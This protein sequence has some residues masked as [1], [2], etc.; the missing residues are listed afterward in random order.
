[1]EDDYMPR[2]ADG[3][4]HERLNASGALLIEGPKWCG[5]TTTGGRLCSSALFMQD[6]DERE[7]NMYYAS[8]RP[9]RLLEG[10][11]PRLIDEWQVAPV[12]WDAVRFAV[13]RDGG[14]GLFVLTGSSVPNL[15][16][17]R[18]KMHSGTGR[19]SR[20]RMHT[21]SLFESGESEGS[22]SVSAL[23]NG[24]TDFDCR[25]DL[26]MERLAFA[27]CRG[28]WPAAVRMDERY[29]L[30][31]A[32]DYVESVST[33][34]ISRAD[35]VMRD[36]Y[37]AKAL[38][39]SLAR[40][41][42]TMAETTAIAEDL[43]GVAS[44]KTVTEYIAALRRI[45]VCDDIPAWRPELMSK[46]RLRTSPKRCFSDPSIAAAAIG[47]APEAL[48]R[49]GPAFGS[50][51]ESLCVRDMRAYL[52]P[53]DGTVMHYHDST[54]LEADMILSLPDGRWA[55]VEV[56]L[57]SGEDKA[58]ENLLRLARKTKTASGDGPSFLAVVTGTGMFRERD[59]G[60]LAI[61]IGCLGP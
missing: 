14:R 39:A 16:K 47:A 17:E 35:G 26:T 55:A 41:V 33:S 53:L 21:M 4:L 19:I 15:E 22:V 52:Q 31:T 11:R 43:G 49:D 37:V 27:T 38:L 59:D 61:P 6:P 9:S 12:L 24:R 58:A 28:G 2:V 50:I 57:R 48:L 25:S 45:F 29:S 5:K 1:M 10:D 30:R 51:F 60:V 42:C 44:R 54:G 23:F 32:M 7:S 20:A 3:Y 36:Q 18:E 34:D 8:K 46:A 13:D 56:K 40:N